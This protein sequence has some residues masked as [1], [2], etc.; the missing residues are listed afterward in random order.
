MRL[1]LDVER[2]GS[3]LETTLDV[4]YESMMISQSCAMPNVVGQPCAS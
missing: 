3:Q 2:H 1:G 4:G